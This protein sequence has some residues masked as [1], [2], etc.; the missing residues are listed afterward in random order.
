MQVQVDAPSHK[1]QRTQVSS[2]NNKI[3]CNCAKNILEKK[4]GNVKNAKNNLHNKNKETYKHTNIWT[5][6]Q[7]VIPT[8][9]VKWNKL[10]KRH[11]NAQDNSNYQ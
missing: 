3:V 8:A 7:K 10:R 9:S 4:S 11:D 5:Q 6:Q 1:F 2:K